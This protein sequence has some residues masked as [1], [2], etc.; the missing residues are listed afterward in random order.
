VNSLSPWIEQVLERGEDR[1]SNQLLPSVYQE[2]RRVAGHRMAH[3]PPGGTLQPTALVHEAFLRISGDAEQIWRDR[4]HFFAAA[5]EAMRHIL[6]DRA[7]RKAAVRHGGGQ[8]PVELESDFVAI[9]L[10]ND[11]LLALDEALERLAAHDPEAAELV[12][13]RFFGGFTF[14]EAG[15]LLNISERTA[16]RVWNYARAWLYEEMARLAVKG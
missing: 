8:R 15:E 5:S 3:Q 14:L 7:R 10:T 16:K 6:I 11:R 2:L 4:Q 9:E 12:K 13:L 1:G